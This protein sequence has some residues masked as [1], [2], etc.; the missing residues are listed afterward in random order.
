MSDLTERLRRI[1]TTPSGYAGISRDELI[2]VADRIDE[3]EEALREAGQLVLWDEDDPCG[4][5]Y[6]V[7][8]RAL[9]ADQ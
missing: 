8:D 5:A 3:L 6:G 2:H 7:I 9:E 4:K 1:A